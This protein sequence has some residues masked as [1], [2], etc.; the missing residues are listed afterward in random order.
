MRRGPRLEP[1]TLTTEENNRLVEWTRR[2]KTSQALALRARIVLACQQDRSNRE[3][4]ERLQVTVQTVGKWRQRFVARRLDGLLDEPRPGA[5]RTIS[6]AVVEKVV[7]KTLHDKPRD[8]THW[9]S[10]TM[11]KASGLSQT[12][13]V[14]IWRAFGLQPHRAETF[15]LSTDP[16]FIDKVRDI[17]GLYLNPPDRALV[18]CVD[19]KS[20][21]QALDRT[22]PILP[23]MPGVPERRTHDYSRHG[24]TTLFAALNIATGKVIGQLRRRHRAKEFLDF[25]RAIEESVPQKLDVHLVM[26]NYGTHKTPAVRRWLARHPRFHAHFTPTSASWLNQVERWF[27]QL[28][29]KQI[30]RG[31]HRSTVELEQAIRSYL[32]VYNR[33]P[34][35]FVWT[36]TADQILESIKRFCMRT[37]NSGH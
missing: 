12:A 25:L 10:R 36:K 22:Q 31:T 33:D 34:K 28:T 16:L 15:K 4:A 26:D 24:T 20:Q 9:S 23:M 5:P 8:A 17:V 32:N 27:A 2:H 21:I 37:S 29:D 1:I 13:V 6:D 14:R 3:I 35:P 7:A 19:E 11:A 30:R 18:L